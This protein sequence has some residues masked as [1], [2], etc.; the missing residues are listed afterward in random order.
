[1][2][3]LEGEVRLYPS[4]VTPVSGW[5]WSHLDGPGCQL[6]VPKDRNLA[7]S[8]YD[9]CRELRF[10][11]KNFGGTAMC[12]LRLEDHED[13]GNNVSI[14]LSGPHHADPTV[15]PNAAMAAKR[16]EWYFHWTTKCEAS[17]DDELEEVV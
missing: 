17:G 16:G 15:D 2:I 9:I 5:N 8:T 13:P 3:T 7:R 1:M 12:S 11:L 6:L 14:R 4:G 10:L